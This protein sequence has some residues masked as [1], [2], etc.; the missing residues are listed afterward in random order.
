MRA[1]RVLAN[2]SSNTVV[3]NNKPSFDNTASS[4]STHISNDWYKIGVTN[5]VK[6]WVDGTKTNYGFMLKDATE[7]NTSQWTTFYSSEAA[8][9]NKPELHI[10]YSKASLTMYSYLDNGFIT[11]FPDGV[12]YVNS[13]HSTVKGILESLF[14]VN[15]EYSVSRF[16]SYCDICK[17]QN[18]GNWDGRHLTG[19]CSHAEKHL[20]VRPDENDTSQGFYFHFIR[21]K[22]V[23]TET[24]SKY[25]WTG[26]IPSPSD[27]LSFSV[28]KYSNGVLHNIV[29]IMP[30]RV[31]EGPRFSN[32]PQDT[33]NNKYSYTLLHETAHQLGVPDHYCYGKNGSDACSNAYCWDCKPELSSTTCVM[34]K[35]YILYMVNRDSMFCP[36]CKAL[37]NKHL[38]NH[39]N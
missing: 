20:S 36:Q 9:P 15:V 23:G 12:Q 8:S 11:R 16:T 22:G 21:T 38:L 32:L 18:N 1:Y 34:Y 29:C 37:I 33:V 24:T 26:H 7:T 5:I 3:W 25:F 27:Q 35:E 39:Y 17:T 13:Y 28:Q 6:T 2:W 19:Y 10:T 30:G 4:L 31:T 14:P